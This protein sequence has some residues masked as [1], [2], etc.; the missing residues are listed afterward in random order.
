MNYYYYFENGE[1]WTERDVVVVAGSG[2][3]S[4]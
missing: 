3:G 2:S 4:I 1:M